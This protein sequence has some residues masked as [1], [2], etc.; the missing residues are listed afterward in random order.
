MRHF[1]HGV[2]SASMIHFSYRYISPIDSLCTPVRRPLNA[3]W[4]ISLAVREEGIRWK[5]LREARGR[6]PDQQGDRSH[7]EGI[8]RDCRAQKGDAV[9]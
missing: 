3:H 5:A 8:P 6:G 2:I 1:P 7:H 4:F 9:P